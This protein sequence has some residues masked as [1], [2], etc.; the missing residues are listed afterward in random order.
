LSQPRWNG[1]PFPG[2]TLL[3]H[4]EQGFGDTLMFVRYARRAKAL[5]GL[6]LLDAQVPLADL[7][8]TCPGVDGVI[9]H[10]SPLPPFDLQ[11]SLHSLPQVFQTTLDTI[12]QEIPYLDIPG[13]VPNRDWVLRTLARSEGQTR[14]GLVWA[15]RRTHKDDQ[16]RSLTPASLAAL[17]SVPGVAWHSFQIDS[18][19]QPPLPGLVILDPMLRNFSDT[20][21]ALSGMNLL[22]TVDTAL[23]HL[24]GALGIPTLLLLPFYPD[25][26]WLLGRED[27]PWYPSMR[28]YRQTSPGDWDGVLARIVS[29]LTGGS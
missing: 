13:H 11:V 22:I 14:I 2:K 27:S 6:V 3:L 18:P 23:A 15:G 25:W 10:G 24:A 28:L 4:Y 7:V 20:A 8:A 9:P 21:F 26:R 19:E 5:G 1:E 17:G 12:P 16:Q 29:D